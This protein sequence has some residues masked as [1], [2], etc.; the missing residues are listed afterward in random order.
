[1]FL[2]SLP[3]AH[4]TSRPHTVAFFVPGRRWIPVAQDPYEPQVGD[5]V[6]VLW[7]DA[8]FWASESGPGD[9]ADSCRVMTYG[10]VCKT[11]D[12]SLFLASERQLDND[13]FR[14]VTRVPF[15]YII[16]VQ[17]LGTEGV[18]DAS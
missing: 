3:L 6:C 9:W 18:P 1:M 8:S 14:A 5:I 15:P 16:G 12:K 4:V 2:R 10:V 17:V 11:T 13:C 7:D